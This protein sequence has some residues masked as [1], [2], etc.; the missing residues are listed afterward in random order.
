MFG[1]IVCVPLAILSDQWRGEDPP[2]NLLDFVNGFRHRLYAA[3]ELARDKMERA[4]GKMKKLYD[5]RMERW[6]FCPGDQVLSLLPIIGSPFQAKFSGPHTV[7]TKISDFNCLIST[8]ERRKNTQ[9]CQ[10]NLLKLYQ[11]RASKYL[12]SEIKYFLGNGIVEPSSSS[13]ASPCTMVPKSD[14]TP[15]FCTDIR[16][17]NAV[18]KPDSFPLPRMEDCVDE[19]GHAKFVSKLDLLKGYWQVPL[20]HRA[21]EISAFVRPNGLFAYRVMPFGLRNAPATFQRL[22]NRVLGDME[23]CTVYLDD[24][25]VFSDSWS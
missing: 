22:M 16:K 7:I 6:V 15:R 5:R 10:V 8:P 11:D 21:R 19:I 24:V 17:G 9:I 14:D 2:R 12:G 18:T 20:T 1:H 3:G 4:Q 13:W 25:V 23:G